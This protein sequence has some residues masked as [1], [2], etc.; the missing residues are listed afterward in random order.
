MFVVFGFDSTHR[1]LEAERL[2]LAAGVDVVPVPTP[3]AIGVGCGIAM[4]IPPE[5]EDAAR[6]TLAAAGIETQGRALIEDL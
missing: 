4:R 2:L 3:P 6:A 5:E 1:A